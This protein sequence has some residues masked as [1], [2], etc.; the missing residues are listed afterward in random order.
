MGRRFMDVEVLWLA[1]SRYSIGSRMIVH[2]H[3]EYYQ[4]YY[5][6]EGTGV[7]VADDEDVPFEPGMFFLLAPGVTHGLRAVDE[8]NGGKARLV[9]MKF[10]VFSP[11]LN[12]SLHS[13]PA[14]NKGSNGLGRAYYEIFLEA[15]QKNFYYEKRVPC[16]FEAWLYKMLRECRRSGKAKGEGEDT[17]SVR[18]KRYIDEHYAEDIALDELA[19]VIGY[20]KSYLCQIFREETGTTINAYL[21]DVRIGHALNLLMT[22]M[23]NVAEVGERCGYNS[24]YYFTKAFKKAMGVPPGSFRQT[25]LAGKRYVE[26]PVETVNT[27]MRNSEV[28]TALYYEN[29]KR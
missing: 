13:L 5:I 28:S 15:I 20:S 17:P 16:L 11:E 27:V 14:V 23:L 7:F 12:E 3:Q 9:E 10:V 19:E 22:P 18:V 6:Q 4:I 24:V 25:E 2:S 1:E 8:D 21:N 26:G 29:D